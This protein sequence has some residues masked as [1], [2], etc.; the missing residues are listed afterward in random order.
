MLVERFVQDS[1][2][3]NLSSSFHNKLKTNPRYMAHQ[4]NRRCDDLI[5][6]LLKVEEDMFHD[7]MRKEVMETPQT[8]SQKVEGEERH[9]RGVNISDTCVQV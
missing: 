8:A 2:N 9:E 3:Y 4:V 6:I 7:R 5:N 1:F